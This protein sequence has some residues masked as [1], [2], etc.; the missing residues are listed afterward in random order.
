LFE[1]LKKHTLIHPKK[2][3]ETSLQITKQKLISTATSRYNRNS[4]LGRYIGCYEEILETAD[5]IEG[6]LF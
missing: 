6:I 2:K 5:T 1:L 3:N 4:K